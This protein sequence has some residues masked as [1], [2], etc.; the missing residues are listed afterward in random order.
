MHFT[1]S[2]ILH[3]NLSSLIK[4]YIAS[5]M[6]RVATFI[7]RGCMT[8]NNKTPY[9][10]EHCIVYIYLHIFNYLF[11]LLPLYSKFR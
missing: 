8:M 6:G 1:N 11:I 2:Q 5:F 10:R 3:F 4:L 9:V 7:P